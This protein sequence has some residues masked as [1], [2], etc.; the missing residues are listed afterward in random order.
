MKVNGKS[1][2]EEKEANKEKQ[3]RRHMKNV[4]RIEKHMEKPGSYQLVEEERLITGKP[5]RIQYNLKLYARV[6][7]ITNPGYPDSLDLVSYRVARIDTTTMAV[8]LIEPS[9]QRGRHIWTGQLIHY[10]LP[11]GDCILEPDSNR[12][13]KLCVARLRGITQHGL[14]NVP[15]GLIELEEHMRQQFSAYYPQ[16]RIPGVR[17]PVRSIRS[18]REVSLTRGLRGGTDQAQLATFPE[19][20]LVEKGSSRV[21]ESAK[22]PSNI[23]EQG[24]T[25][26]TPDQPESRYSVPVLRTTANE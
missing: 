5:N 14:L 12:C 3:I 21:Q 24:L 17:M 15:Q 7:V 4:K 9:S 2:Q 1:D 26:S 22:I 6:P 16:R 8:I 18:T 25:P 13:I 20:R 19:L 10:G 23:D 11:F